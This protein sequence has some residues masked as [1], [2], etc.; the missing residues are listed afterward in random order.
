MPVHRVLL[1]APLATLIAS[2]WCAALP[3][4]PAPIAGDEHALEL[5]DRASPL[6]APP[7]AATSPELLAAGMA[8]LERP[9]M[10]QDPD[11]EP[12]YPNMYT[13]LELSLGMA[14]YDNFDTSLQVRADEGVGTLVDLEDL[15]GMDENQAVFRADTFYRFAKRHRLNLSY[16][17]IGRDGSKTTS[18]DITIGNVTFPAGS[19]VKS[20]LDTLIVKLSYQYDFVADERTAIGASLGLHAMKV[21][22]EFKTQSGSIKETFNATAPL[23]VI[24]LHGEYALSPTWKLAASAEVFQVE[25]GDFGGFLADNRLSIENNLFRNV[26]WGLGFNGFT[27]DAHMDD[28]SL[29]GDLEYSFQGLMLY[30][31]AIL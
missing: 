6:P 1:T 11:P 29:T 23:P 24:G 14:D 7:A 3:P 19:G 15:L 17:D 31:R 30:L 20:E 9:S 10:T 26:G 5:T 16:Y 12:A 4:V 28:S 25:L 18:Q 8:L 21:D 22:S 27:L 2:T 13:T